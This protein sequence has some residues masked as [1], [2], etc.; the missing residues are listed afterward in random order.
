MSPFRLAASI[1]AL[2]GA[3][4]VSGCGSRPVTGQAEAD[5]QTRAACRARAAEVYDQQ[6]QGAIYSAPPPVNMPYSGNY[7]PQVTDRGLSD[8]FAHDRMVNDCIRNS[9]TGAEV[10]SAPKPAPTAKPSAE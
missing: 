6:N 3:V 1:G 10:T 9:G 5:A 2:L 8:L 4:A 7:T